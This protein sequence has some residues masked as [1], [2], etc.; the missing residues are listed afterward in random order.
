MASVQNLVLNIVSFWEK[1]ATKKNTYLMN[2]T[3]KFNAVD[4]HVSG[5]Y[6]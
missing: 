3:K 1:T 5:P 6:S 2:V 4:P